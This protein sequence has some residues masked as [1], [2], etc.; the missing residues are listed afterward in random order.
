LSIGSLFVMIQMTG[1]IKLHG[2]G[3]RVHES[4]HGWIGLRKK[5][6]SFWKIPG[7]DPNADSGREADVT[8]RVAK[9][10]SGSSRSMPM[11]P[12]DE[13]VTVDDVAVAAAAVGQGP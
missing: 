10:R 12:A 6:F 9:E 11:A 4:V 3:S 13:I 8:R 5:P 2:F 7:G 1:Q